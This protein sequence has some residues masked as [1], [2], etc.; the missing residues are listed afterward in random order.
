MK[1]VIIIG[2]GLVGLSV[3]YRLSKI[4]RNIK[5]TVLE[6][7]A[8]L[9]SHQST[10]NSGVMHCGLH[11]KPKSLKAKLSVS[12]I[13][14]L[15]KFCEMNEINY[16]L[17]GKIVVSASKKD[18]KTIDELAKRGKSNG[19]KNLRIL[20]NSEIRK[21]EPFVYSKKALLVPDE[22]IVDYKS[23]VLKLANNIK[24][25]DHEI[26]TNSNVKKII[27]KNN[28]NIV[29]LE[30]KQEI[31]CDYFVNCA[32]LYS[33]RVFN[34]SYANSLTLKIVP[35][36]GEYMKMNEEGSKLFNHLVYPAPDFKFPF[37]GVHFT[38]TISNHKLIGPNAVLAFHREGYSNK[39][40]SLKDF[41]EIISYKGFHNFVLNNFIFSLKQLKTSL[42]I[43]DFVKEGRKII[44]E[45]KLNHFEKYD[46]GVRAQAIDLSGKLV[47]DFYIKRKLNQI[48][49][50][51]A[52][53]PAAT[54]S[55]AI[56]D[57]IIE[58]FLHDLI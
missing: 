18:E 21:R 49:V 37:L 54:S 5:I 2:G 51:N 47:E 43:S 52:P 9:G 16:D 17:C 50:L 22:G 14:K 44:P 1:K 13:N 26:N 46:S 36:R 27:I 28:K 3:A 11:Y 10:R 24:K 4:S 53:S 15:V 30:N 48:H 32:G 39:K 19:L 58:N 23:V 45:L 29:V 12:G 6:K 57:Y 41:F 31:E 56:A 38:R 20:D 7:E 8:K 33:D 35:F 34:S 40:F 42:S 55:L 25:R